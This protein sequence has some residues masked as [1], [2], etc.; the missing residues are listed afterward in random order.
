MVVNILFVKRL[1]FVAGTFIACF[2]IHWRLN[3]AMR[4]IP[5]NPN[6]STETF[7]RIEMPRRNV[8]VTNAHSRRQVED[9]EVMF[10]PG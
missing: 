8:P 6:P 9:D 10:V 1:A 7:F 3:I 2:P 5:R 4:L